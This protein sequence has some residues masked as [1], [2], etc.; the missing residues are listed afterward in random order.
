M[1]IRASYSIP[2]CRYLAK[3]PC[4][5]KRSSCGC[6]IEGVWQLIPNTHPWCP[7][8]HDAVTP[9]V[10][11]KVAEAGIWVLCHYLVNVGVDWCAIACFMFFIFGPVFEKEEH[12]Y[13]SWNLKKHRCKGIFFGILAEYYVRIFSYITFFIL[14]F[15]C[16]KA[17]EY[18][19]NVGIFLIDSV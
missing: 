15:T 19:C 1:A 3:K 16:E 13:Q 7:G 5:S 11:C 17:V 6:M 8:I 2:E 4:F 12:S 9:L 18:Q 14:F 10:I